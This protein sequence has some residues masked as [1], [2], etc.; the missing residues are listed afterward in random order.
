MEERELELKK[1]F[2]SLHQRHNEVR[3][4]GGGEWV[5][6]VRQW[7]TNAPRR[8]PLQ[9]IHNYMEHVER[10]KMQQFSDTSESSAVGRVRWGGGALAVENTEP[11]LY[12]VPARKS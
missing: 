11:S 3:E 9:M 1:E 2:N 12:R 8:S 5:R 7:D 6:W 10:I 4:W